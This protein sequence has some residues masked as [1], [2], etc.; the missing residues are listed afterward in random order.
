MNTVFIKVQELMALSQWFQAIR[1]S[2][3]LLNGYQGSPF[4][5]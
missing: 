1:S 3:E 5:I 2:D 4:Y